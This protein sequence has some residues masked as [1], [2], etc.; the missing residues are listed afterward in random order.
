L[1]EKNIERA[2]RPRRFQIFFPN[3]ITITLESDR[4]VAHGCLNLF[5]GDETVEGTFIAEQGI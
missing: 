2:T 3:R 5:I 4:D 1:L